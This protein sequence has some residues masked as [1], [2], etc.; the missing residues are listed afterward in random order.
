MEKSKF[1]SLIAN[2][3]ETAEKDNWKVQYNK[4]LDTF[5]WSRQTISADAELKQ[6]LDD[7][8]LY[9]NAKGDIEGVFIEYAKFNFFSHHKIWSR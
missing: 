9:I 3:K 5:Y 6:F 8:S 2:L 1:L 4:E 7:F